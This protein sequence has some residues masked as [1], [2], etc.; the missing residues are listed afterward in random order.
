MGTLT[1]ARYAL[2]MSLMS[3]NFCRKSE[4]L[5]AAASLLLAKRM[6]GTADEWVFFFD[7]F[8][9]QFAFEQFVKFHGIVQRSSGYSLAELEPLMWELNKMLVN[10]ESQ[11]GNLENVFRK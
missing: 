5:I 7:L 11:F 6:K 9:F 1:L 8:K 2:E 4:S 10:R 3:L